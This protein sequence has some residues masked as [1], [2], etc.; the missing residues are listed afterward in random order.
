MSTDSYRELCRGPKR[1]PLFFK[2]HGFHWSK[3][4]AQSRRV[5]FTFRLLLFSRLFLLFFASHLF[6]FLD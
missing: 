1:G 6:C 5:L 3:M 4:C 2:K